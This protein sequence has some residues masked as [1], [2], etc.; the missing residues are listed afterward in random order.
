[1]KYKTYPKMK[2]SG[3]DWVGDIPE[4]WKVTKLKYA[5]K[6]NPPKSELNSF[7]DNYKVS[8]LPMERIGE[9]GKLDLE[10]KKELHEVKN[11]FTYFRNNDVII[12]KITPCFEN[13]KG[14][15]CKNLHNDI[16]FGTTELHV[17]RNTS[18]FDPNLIF[19][20]SR[21]HPFMQTGE[22]LMYGAA[23]Q[24]RISSEF[25]KEFIIAYPEL[26][27][28]QKQ[29]AKFL[30][31]QTTKIDSEIKKN[32]KLVTLLQEK[33][34]ATI[35]H[36]VT[37]GL[38]DSVP[39]KDSG[40]EWIGDIPEKWNNKRLKY[41]LKKIVDNRGRT[42]PFSSDGI[43][44]LEIPN[45]T[46]GVREPTL[47]FEKFV[48]SDLVDIFERDKVEVGDILISTVG[49]TS[50]RVVI[51]KEKPTYFICQNI[52]GLRFKEIINSVYLFYF[53]KSNFFKTSLILINKTNT[54][55]NLK[56]S[57]FINN[58]CFIPESKIEQTQ[59][60]EF[61]DSQTSKID[62]LISKAKLQIKTLQE[63][64]QSLISSAVT[65]KICVTN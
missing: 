12:A 28:E 51:I 15:L 54:I 46:N 1:M 65:G 62:N 49:A 21:S 30:D 42:P 4:E 23:G 61:L 37:K 35:N 22:S 43:P 34:Q 16:G 48:K 55:D 20:W 63:Y 41:L 36:A 60:A 53:L 19:Y 33:K 47:S 25:I 5:C 56:V 26:I 14:S 29:I 13:G 9:D 52:V 24:K 10:E 3:I 58:L 8:F 2:D 6:F 39:M 7:S 27:T 44:M 57:I 11:G 17:L 50:G 18:N 45:I 64:R 59:I 38:D 31:S 32:E 40:V